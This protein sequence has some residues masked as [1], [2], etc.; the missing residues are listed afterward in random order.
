M[1]EDDLGDVSRCVATAKDISMDAAEEEHKNVTEGCSMFRTCHCFTPDWL[2]QELIKITVLSGQLLGL[3][4][5]SA[6]LLSEHFLWT[7]EK[8]MIPYVG[9]TGLD[10]RTV[11]FLL[12]RRFLLYFGHCGCFKYIGNMLWNIFPARNN[13]L[14]LKRFQLIQPANLTLIAFWQIPHANKWCG[15]YVQNGVSGQMPVF[16]INERPC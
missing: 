5:C 9:F 11:F 13:R 10:N 6:R 3:W 16:R 4:A 12:H 7:L 8:Q 1:T 2:K 14:V 15:V